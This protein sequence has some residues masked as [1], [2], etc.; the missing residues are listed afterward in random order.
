MRIK[1]SHQP[2]ACNQLKAGECRWPLT[3]EQHAP[4]PSLAQRGEEQRP[5]LCRGGRGQRLLRECERAELLYPPPSYRAVGR[6]EEGL[7][8]PDN[9]VAPEGAAQ[10]GEGERAGELYARRGLVPS[11]EGEAHLPGARREGG[12]KG[13]GEGVKGVR[14]CPLLGLSLVEGE[15]HQEVG[16]SKRLLSGVNRRA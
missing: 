4:Q 15:A 9:G 5:G 2:D 13:G 10:V 1:R 14:P 16:V 7:V 12:V 3:R 8:A 6:R 11:V